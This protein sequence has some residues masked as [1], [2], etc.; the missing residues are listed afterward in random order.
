MKTIDSNELLSAY[1][2]RSS[3]LLRLKEQGDEET[4]REFYNIYGR[5]IFGYALRHGLS[6]A[7]AEDV[8]QNVCVK[9]FRHIF[10]FNYSTELGS[11][12]GW[13]KTVTKNAVFD[14]LRRRS[15][16]AGLFEGYRD[17]A[18]VMHEEKRAV[19]DSVWDAEW[20]K[21]VLEAALQRVYGRIN[22]QSRKA[23][24]LFAVEN[25][26]AGEVAER[27]DMEAN[28]V[29]ACKHRVLKLVREEVEILKDEI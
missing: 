3:L 5:M 17:H 4:W 21:A 29:Y 24:Q 20:E 23:F 9:L 25:L 27:L 1:R 26:S 12:R 2:T 28:A 7:E 16:R 15:R 18:A 10:S 6:H 13:L 8:V 14:Y 11:F 19:D 22:E